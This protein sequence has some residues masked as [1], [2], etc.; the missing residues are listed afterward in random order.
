MAC[1]CAF[2]F[3]FHTSLSVATLKRCCRTSRSRLRQP[4]SGGKKGGRWT[5]RHFLGM[6]AFAARTRPWFRTA[7]RCHSV[8]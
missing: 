1:F 5:T 7:L 2:P 4:L 8:R 6:A 3:D